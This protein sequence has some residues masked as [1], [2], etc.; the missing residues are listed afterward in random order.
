[1]RYNS[2]N[3]ARTNPEVINLAALELRAADESLNKADHA[4][5]ENKSDD[6]VDHLAYIAKQQVAIAEE[7]AKWKTAELAVTN[8]AVKRDLA[9][10]LARTAEAAAA[11]QRAVISQQTV[12]RQAGELAVCRR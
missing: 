6:I 8:A 12:D 11:K 7:T 4:L 3:S 5:S 10:R 1:M 9:C 2:Y